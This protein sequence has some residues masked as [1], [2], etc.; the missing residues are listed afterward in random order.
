M[1]SAR[2][3]ART[4]RSAVVGWTAALLAI[5][6]SLPGYPLGARP[7]VSE[8]A[9]SL[10]AEAGSSR[11]LCAVVEGKPELALELAKQSE[12]LVHV[13][14]SELNAVRA[15]RRGA[16]D[17]KLSLK[18]LA[19]E[20]GE[21]ER[22][23]YAENSVD[24]LIVP[25]SGWTT[26]GEPEPGKPAPGRLP[27]QEAVRVLRPLGTLLIEASVEAAANWTEALDGAGASQV[28]GWLRWTK[29]AL[30]GTDSWSHW[31][32]GPD[33]N[34]VSADTVIRAPYL[35]Q[36][37]AKPYYIGMPSI[38]TAAGGRTF[39]AV[40]HIAH[41]EREWQT[42]YTLM[43]RNGYNG[44]V[45]WERKLPD[46][47][48]VHRSAFIATAETF[49]MIDGDRCLLLD[50]ETGRDKGE[51]RIPDCPGD[52]SWMAMLDNRLYVLAGKPA[53]PTEATKGS[54][55]FG[56]W[57]WGDLSKGYYGK[58]IPFGFG[59]VLA[60]YDL[61]EKRTLWIHREETLIDSRG[62][63]LDADRFY[64]YCPDRHLRALDTKTG[65]V[66]W[67]NNDED[68]LSLIEAPG[69]KL[70]ST[71]GFRT[72]TLVVRTPEALVIQGQ[73]RMNVIAI[74]TRNGYLL[75]KKPKITNNPNAV[76][77]DGKIVLGVGKG[78]SHVALD[79]ISG[80]VEE[81]LKFHKRA[82]TRLTATPDSLFCRGEGT[83][84]FDREKRTF[85]VDGAARPACNDGAIAANGMLYIGP[86]QCD[87]N[88][89]L[90]G[91]LGKCSAG[92][93]RF[94]YEVKAEE[95]LRVA[96]TVRTDG[97]DSTGSADIG[98]ADG[99]DWP[100]DRGSARRGGASTVAISGGS[101]RLWYMRPPTPTVPTAPVSAAGMVFVGG[102]DGVVRALDAASGDRRW[103]HATAGAILQPPT[104]ADGSV[105]VGRGDGWVSALDAKSGR[106]VWEFRAAPV[107]RHIMTYG[108]LGS[109]WPVHTG[110]LVNEGTAYF[111]AGIIDTDGTYLYALDAKTGAF[112]WQ[113]N[114]AGHLNA[115]LRKGVSAQGNLT[116]RNDLLLLAGGNQISPAPFEAKT[117]NC[118][119]GPLGNG[120][121]KAN[122]G[123]FVGVFNDDVVIAGGRIL[124]SAP[125]N[126]ATKASFDA[127]TAKHR[128]RLAF[129]GV[130]PAWNDT[131]LVFV[132]YR[133]GKIT[134]CDA[135]RAGARMVEGFASKDGR[136]R[137]WN[138]T[139]ADTFV[140][141]DVAL[142]A[143]DLDA[144]KFETISLALTPNAV[145]ATVRLQ[146][147][148]RARRDWFV[149]GLNVKDGKQLFRQRLD[150]EPLPG[151]LLIDRDGR[152]VIT[153]VSGTVTCYGDRA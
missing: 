63:A 123:R 21:L 133:H 41:H 99:R 66:T 153:S 56:G 90:I 136:R 131:H 128:L 44:T 52:W 150:E 49:Y 145:V 97:A 35:S 129:G 58:R 38:T 88:L 13:R 92:D 125:Q 85:S 82:C 91:H 135:K 51:I 144:E 4:Q 11:G 124:Y 78:G 113:N 54:R 73:T 15:I 62:L 103:T 117:G 16:A 89:S 94:D 69:R 65:K 83:L 40:G 22:L 138:A 142:W 59:D 80:Q 27:V 14:H 68:T 95:R 47:Y 25:R 12:L 45:L 31:E 77:V 93:F 105:F 10:L 84:R 60:A 107:E 7:L 134:L 71:P 79:P 61:K 53:V 109:T 140:R 141:A 76:Y 20:L 36:F 112:Q 120:Q 1:L 118:L 70:T 33:N 122:A 46:G 9:K 5:A 2:N 115:D 143:T 57:S 50:P 29:P 137:P 3:F 30:L 37:F 130:T 116:L 26:A 149:L 8:T 114:S 75:W 111:A 146:E 101:E 151:G 48:L 132:N 32:H 106:L 98:K 110:V 100:T 81:E 19:A 67:T 64:L 139:L 39:L 119:A 102:D 74:S 43:G 34:P 24:V 127:V 42:L 28:A 86:W 87:C 18:R 6:A 147:K 72:Q 148:H 152:I 121:P 104:V 17:A 96:P 23:P 55:S 108:V 126:V